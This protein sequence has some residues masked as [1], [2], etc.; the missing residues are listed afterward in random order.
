MD[1]YITVRGSGTDELVEKKSRFIAN[2]SPVFSEEEAISFI[3][4]IKKRYWD[5][6]H[7][8]YAYSIGTGS[9][10][11]YRYSD[12]GEPGGT[13]GMPMLDVIRGRDI[14]NAIVVVTRYFGGTLLGT[15]GLVRAYSGAA[16]LGLKAAGLKERIPNIRQH[17]TVDYTLSGKVQYDILNGGHT[18]ENT[19]YTDKVEFVAL[20]E[21]DKALALKE[22]II[23][24]TG[25]KVE[26][27]TEEDVVY[28]D[29]A[30]EF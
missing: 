30:I 12:D 4:G 10:P 20:S 17:F 7:S 6:R 22:S 28:A 26:I 15:G 29:K 1:K 18:L 5:A 3:E 21:R 14:R 27:V 9:N 13:A 11:L 16:R 25:N 19:V 24:I 8:C 23:N 2:V